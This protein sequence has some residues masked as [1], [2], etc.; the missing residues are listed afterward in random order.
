MKVK[1]AWTSRLLSFTMGHGCGLPRAKEQDPGL[2]P[3][4]VLAPC[5]AGRCAPQLWRPH[6]SCP[7]LGSP[8]RTAG[9]PSRPGLRAPAPAGAGPAWRRLGPGSGSRS[10]GRGLLHW[11]KAG[12]EGAIE[13]LRVSDHEG[14]FREGV[15]ETKGRTHIGPEVV[16]APAEVL[17]EGMGSDDHPGGSVP[18]QPSHG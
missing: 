10:G 2:V 6:P 15:G 8:S 12:R 16:E 11:L 13:R 17:D 18:L 14:Q 7:S 4:A 3:A 9:T 5:G 1:S